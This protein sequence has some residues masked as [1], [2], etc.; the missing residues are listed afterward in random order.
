MAVSSIAGKLTI[1]DCDFSSNAAVDGAAIYESSSG[2]LSIINSRFEHN[3]AFAGGG[4]FVFAGSV[5]ISG[6]TFENNDAFRAGGAIYNSGTLSLNHSV[7]ESNS[8]GSDSLGSGGAVANLGKMK[9]YGCSFSSNYAGSKGGAL[10]NSTS[11]TLS[12]TNASFFGNNSGFSGG[13]IFV[14][15]GVVDI[16]G[17]TFADND[18]DYG[19]G[20]GD[21]GGTLALENST[22][23]GNHAEFEGG[24][25]FVS[26]SGEIID[27]ANDSDP[28]GILTA[29]NVTIAN[30]TAEIE[31]GGGAGL[32]VAE[33][34][35][36]SLCN[37]LV[38]RNYAFGEDES[39]PPSDITTS[40]DGLVTG[41]NNLVGIGGSGQLS[42][43]L[44]L[45][46]VIHP[47]LA[48]LADNGG[49]TDTIALEPGSPAIDA[50][51]NSIPGVIV[52]IIDQRGALRGPAGLNAGPGPDIGAYEASSSYLVSTTTDSDDV[53]TLRTA[54]GWANVSTNANPENTVII[55]P[56]T[57]VFDT[58]GVFS[59]PQTITLNTALGTLEFLG[60]AVPIAIDGPGPNMVSISGGGKL[61]IFQVDDDVSVTCIGLTLTN[62]AAGVGGALTN[63]GIST[64]ADCVF[65]D[66]TAFGG[67]AIQ[68]VGTVIVADST[69]VDNSAYSANGGA[70]SNNGTMTVS[71]ST[72][73]G[74]SAYTG[75]GAIVTFEPLTLT[76]VT[77][78]GNLARQAGGAI[79]LMQGMVQ[80]PARSSPMTT[81][82]ARP[83]ASPL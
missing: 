77:L 61:E 76:N 35:T 12:V 44:N 34:G 32:F 26:A 81:V 64:I 36:A 6:T 58:N 75:G 53:G 30:N 38:A 70:I 3:S 49:P 47:G 22:L 1:G 55:A 20:V 37:T 25:I 62:G 5:T 16:T 17:S 83:P 24:A 11:A 66:N 9:A 71:D 8:A 72:F 68:N 31:G 4:I 73:T 15:S 57:I 82:T 56:N 29:V 13:G 7:F 40:G 50:G 39:D 23:S 65:S 48:P 46:N 59:T 19:G 2:Q 21:F 54:V 42:G 63:A 60:T 45:L 80:N 28:P 14:S 41:Q 69:F 27:D 67:G 52:P 10:Y 33:G 18:A 51:S 43:K 74:N 79:Q 78:S